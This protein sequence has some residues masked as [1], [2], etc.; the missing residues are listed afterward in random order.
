MDGE[1]LHVSSED[2]NNGELVYI[3]VPPLVAYSMPPSAETDFVLTLAG[4]TDYNSSTGNPQ[5]ESSLLEYIGRQCIQ[6]RLATKLA[7]LKKHTNLHDLFPFL[8]N[9]TFPNMPAK[10]DGTTSCFP[11]FVNKKYV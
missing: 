8:R 3:V 7:E 1:S 11:N 9:S 4:I 10:I 5:N 2:E 6:N